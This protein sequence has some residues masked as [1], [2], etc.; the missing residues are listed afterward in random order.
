[1]AVLLFWSIKKLSSRIKKF[2]GLSTIYLDQTRQKFKFR[3]VTLIKAH[4]HLIVVEQVIGRMFNILTLFE[5]LRPIGNM[6]QF[7]LIWTAPWPEWTP[8]DIPLSQNLHYILRRCV[9]M[10]LNFQFNFQVKFV[11]RLNLI[12]TEWIT[13]NPI[14]CGVSIWLSK[15]DGEPVKAPF[16]IESKGFLCTNF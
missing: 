6:K 10:Q 16:S 8:L 13:F 3:A 5:N 4:I 1:M 9:S 15:I 14:R 11:T 7:S 2:L 12:D